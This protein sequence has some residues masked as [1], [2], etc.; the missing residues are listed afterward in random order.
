MRRIKVLYLAQHLTMGGAEE[1]LRGVAIGLPRERFE[2]VVGC[3]TREGL[4]ARELR[5][6]G[7]RVVPLPGEPGPRDP[8]AF[9]RLLK[10]IRQ[11]RP[12]VAHTFLLNA[13]LYG[14]LAAWLARVPAIY[15]AEQNLYIRK[16][17]RHLALERFLAGRT[18]RIVACCQA[19]AE[20]YQR[21]VGLYPARLEVI[22]N[23]VDFAAVE[24]R[25]DRQAARAALGYGPDDV[26]LGAVG[27]LGEQK[28]HD[29]LLAALAQL[30]VREPRLRCFVAGQ[31]PLQAA[32]EQQ[33]ARLG[34]ADRVR[35]LGVR[36]ERDLL[37]GAMDIFV[38]P[39]R[40]EG[41]SLALVEATG[42]GLPVVT[43]DVGGNAEV[44]GDQPGT[45]LVA[46]DDSAALA[47]ALGEAVASLA[48]TRRYGRPVVR[49]RFSLAS[50]LERLEASYRAALGVTSTRRRAASPCA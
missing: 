40:W 41:L 15:H 43:T 1:L 13:G 27:R 47:G 50:H 2:V 21:Q 33:A 36:R 37:Y 25:A 39:S 29:V 16:S 48:A 32:L 11:E 5:E 12:D 46:A 23:A 31:G 7:V 34:L 26:I 10:F 30:A 17:A 14:R 24:P 9:V 28:A 3:L 42:V 44:V 22:Y 8:A 35:F 45:W 38:L 19:V 49:D 18:A 6:A 4:V 20:L